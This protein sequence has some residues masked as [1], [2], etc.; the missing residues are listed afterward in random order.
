MTAAPG[1]IS[2][3]PGTYAAVPEAAASAAGSAGSYR[4][5]VPPGGANDSSMQL[6]YGGNV[7]SGYLQGGY[8]AAPAGLRPAE[9]VILQPGNRLVTVTAVQQVQQ[10]PVHLQ[11][12]QGKL[13]SDAGSTLPQSG[14]ATQQQHQVYAGQ[15][16]QQVGAI[17]VSSTF[18]QQ[19]EAAFGVASQFQQLQLQQQMRQQQLQ[20]QQQARQL[21]YEHQLQLQRL[22]QQQAQQLLPAQ[23]QQQLGQMDAQHLQE[24]IEQLRLQQSP[25][26]M[27]QSASSTLPSTGRVSSSFEWSGGHVVTPQRAHSFSTSYELVPSRSLSSNY[28][29]RTSSSFTS[30]QSA[31]HALLHRMRTASGEGFGTPSVRLSCDLAQG[32]GEDYGNQV[33]VL[34][35]QMPNAGNMQQ[36]NHLSGLLPQLQEM[37]ADS[38]WG[39]QHMVGSGTLQRA[40]QQTAVPALHQD[41]LI[42]GSPSDLSPVQQQ[43]QQQLGMGGTLVVQ[44]GLQQQQQQQLLACQGFGTSVSNADAA[45]SG[46]LLQS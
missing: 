41:T 18:P 30:H 20:H 8:G 14:A 34:P 31:S 17:S 43:Q 16:Q 21:Q 6:Q 38:S 37:A 3:V 32:T 36:A 24:Q 33:L 35:G 45:V 27:L 5:Q 7:G 40:G 22:Q 39:S 11:T 12:L 13:Q 29:G 46:L 19:Q 25:Q 26:A 44:Q 1:H 28:T 23:Q 2:Q 4:P 15:H 10:M 9:Q 42:L